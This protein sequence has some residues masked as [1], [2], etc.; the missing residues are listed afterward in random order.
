MM[1]KMKRKEKEESFAV[2]ETMKQKRS[3]RGGVVAKTKR[4]TRKELSIVKL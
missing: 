4:K 1:T 3:E 2:E